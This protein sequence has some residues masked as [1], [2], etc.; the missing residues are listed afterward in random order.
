MCDVMDKLGDRS[1]EE[2]VRAKV[3]ALC[4]VHPVPA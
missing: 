4:D 3:K 2:A 1:V